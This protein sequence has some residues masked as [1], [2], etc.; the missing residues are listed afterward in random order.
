[1]PEVFMKKIIGN[2]LIGAGCFLVGLINYFVNGDKI[3]F[4]MSFIISLCLSV[5]VVSLYKIYKANNYNIVE[6]ICI[7]TE[8]KLFAGYIIAEIETEEDI[9][10]LYLPKD[11]K[12]QLNCKYAFYFK[13]IPVKITGI[14]SPEMLCKFNSDS[15]LGFSEI[16]DKN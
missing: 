16:L 4:I 8:R 7:R 9:I 15:F 6:G 14:L 10:K 13:N 5:R 12:L 3:I 1:M 2:I 11:T